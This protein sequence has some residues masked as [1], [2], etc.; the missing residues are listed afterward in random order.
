MSVIIVLVIIDTIIQLL[1]CHL[2]LWWF[3]SLICR[4]AFCMRIIGATF[5]I[6]SMAIGEG[7]AFALM[8]L[9]YAVFKKGSIPWV[10]I[11]LYLLMSLIAL[12]L[13]ALDNFMYVYDVED[14]EDD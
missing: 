2:S 13:E 3:I 7:V 12:G 6:K 1:V 14:Y 5:K 10:T 4:I 9:F 11:G 8:V